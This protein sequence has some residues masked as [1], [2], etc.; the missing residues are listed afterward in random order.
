[1]RLTIFGATGATG[2][3]L[4]RQALAQGHALA[5]L[6][7][8]PAAAKLPAEVNQVQGDVRDSVAVA[9]AIVGS[10]AVLSAIG[11]RSVRESGLLD[12]ASA[13]IL[14]GMKNSGVRRLIVL[15]AQGAAEDSDINQSVAYRLVFAV[16]MRTL[17]KRPFEDQRAQER[18]LQASD[19]DYTVVRPPRLTNGPYTGRYR[20]DVD[21]LP[22]AAKSTARADVADFMLKQ[23]KDERF[24]RRGV[25]IAR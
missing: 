23:I 2:M 20:I 11:A 19:I 8:N 6:V 22:R 3:E 17:L 24:L 4:V 16:L 12:T 1:M 21:T 13:N 18:R 15:G 14:D 7:R 9:K 5:C 25:Y 10:E